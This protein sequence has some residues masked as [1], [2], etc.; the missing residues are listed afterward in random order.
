M[1]ILGIHDGHNSGACIL[2][3]GRVVSAVSTERVS[4]V[5]N[6]TGYSPA[7]IAEVLKIAGLKPS[8]ISMVAIASTRRSTKDWFMQTDAWYKS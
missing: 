2:Q 1:Y 5:K 7:A 4:R 8:G 3:D 6:D